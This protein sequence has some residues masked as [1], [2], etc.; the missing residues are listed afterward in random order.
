MPYPV[1]S[2]AYARA[3]QADSTRGGGP[4]KR[5][6]WSYPDSPSYTSPTKNPFG[7]AF[8]DSASR[9]TNAAEIG[10]DLG[11]SPLTRA[12]TGDGSMGGWTASEVGGI[13]LQEM[14]ASGSEKTMERQQT[15][16]TIDLS[17]MDGM[18][19]GE[20]EEEEDSPY[21]EVRASV[22]NL[23]DPDMPVLTF[24]S[25]FLGLSCAAVFSAVNCFFMFRYPAPLVYPIVIQVF[26]HPL[27][28]FLAL[29]LPTREW[30]TPKFLQKLGMGEYMSLNPGPW[31]IKE[32]TI[33][34]L[35][36]NTAISPGYSLNYT[37]SL[38]VTHS[39]N[40]GWGFNFLLLLTTQYVGFGVAGLCRKFLVWPAN[41]IWP[42][43]L[44]HATLFNTLHAEE[45]EVE[46]EEGEKGL[47][48]FRLFVW[49]FGGAFVWYFF[50]D[51]KVV[52]QLFGLSSGLGMS[53][54]TFDWSQ[55]SYIGSPLVTPWW[56]EVQ[57]MIGFVLAFWVA[58]PVLYYTNAWNT[59]YLPISTSGIFDRFGASYDFTGLIDSTDNKLNVTAYEA[60]SPLYLPTTYA[61]VYA[62][63]CAVVT[64]AL[65]HTALYQGKDILRAMRNNTRPED[66]DIHAKLMR[67]YPEVPN[68]WYLGFLIISVGLS[69]ATAW[70]TDLPVGLLLFSLFLGAIYILPGGYI[71]ST[72][73]QQLPTNLI[74]ELAAGYMLPG[75]ALG[76][77]L[78]KIY[79][80]Q[81]VGLGVAFVQDLKIGHYMKIPPRA[82]FTGKPL[83]VVAVALTTLVQLATT[84]FM[85]DSVPGF[86]D[87]Q[88]KNLMTCPQTRAMES[89]SIVWGLIGPSRL[90]GSGK[91]YNPILWF[92]LI[93]ACL[94]AIFWALERR[95]PKTRWLSH[96]NIPVMITGATFMPPATGIN[97]SSWF[98]VGFIFQY[99]L[100]RRYFR[101]WSKFNFIISAGLDSGTV[102]SGLFIFFTLQLPKAGTIA[103]NWWGNTVYTNT[104]DWNGVPL[105]T[106]PAEGF[107]PTKWAPE[108]DALAGLQRQGTMTW[109]RS[110]DSEDEVAKGCFGGGNGLAPYLIPLLCLCGTGG[111]H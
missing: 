74:V 45:D 86:C 64:A 59:A 47:S 61:A 49:V 82:T 32:H 79:S 75:R 33:I 69:V 55:I 24:R 96:V 23:D 15:A 9:G 38:R 84:E 72:S 99:W 42:Q 77:M 93:G 62:L 11:T 101:A 6:I 54:L 27:G 71:F 98:F 37:V 34:I 108:V 13:S 90:F 2:S 92:L 107:G 68:W 1:Q 22:S 51:N 85:L 29:V 88:Q 83:Q 43:N 52:N 67:N 97:Y 57:I 14:R 111:A 16:T 91:M 70:D 46:D 39:Q 12:E 40:F 41:V 109:R 89:A 17:Y 5:S 105:L 19:V 36:C 58:C 3:I 73:A 7:K 26:S 80:T 50:P 100:R 87:A 110:T 81:V 65:V 20:M 31:N 63:G 76:G 103:I 94:P 44:V 30:R 56:A 8:R 25:W 10:H 48:R 53:F 35:M 95:F 18:G 21:P 104:D 4:R 66:E 78:F 60:Y 106:P 102:A 28:K